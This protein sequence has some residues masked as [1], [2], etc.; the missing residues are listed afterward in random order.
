MNK[1]KNNKIRSFFAGCLLT[2]AFAVAFQ[3]CELDNY[4]AADAVV[5]GVIMEATTNEPFQTQTPDGA[6]VRF[7]ENYNGVWSTQP[8]DVWVHQDGAFNNNAAF[9]GEYKMV[10][11][12]A[13]FPVDTQTI[14]ISGAN[15]LTINVTSYLIIDIETRTSGGSISATAR[16]R[17]ASSAG[18]INDIVF[19]ISD[20]PYVDNNVWVQRDSRTMTSVPDEEI[21]NTGYSC[22]FSGL[23]AGQTYYVRVAARAANDANA[24]NY[25]KIVAVKV[26]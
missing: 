1:M 9:S 7:Y 3:G 20:S 10:A 23:D 21:I 12:G 5:E 24:Y 2:A 25:S 4:E 6:R 14:R 15:K 11:I 19:L 18:K 8:Y 22:S 16:I 26:E 13:F 17:K